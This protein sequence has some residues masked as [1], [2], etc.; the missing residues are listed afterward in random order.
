MLQRKHTY[1]R[2]MPRKEEGRA[3]LNVYLAGVHSSQYPS[4]ATDEACHR[5]SLVATLSLRRLVPW[6]IL[7]VPIV[8]G[9][10]VNSY[11]QSR[12]RRKM[13]VG[14]LIPPCENLSFLVLG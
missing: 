10:S 14:R 8:T 6:G 7:R 13:Q 12:E 1:E 3:F 4:M 9:R 5:R 2:N 11:P